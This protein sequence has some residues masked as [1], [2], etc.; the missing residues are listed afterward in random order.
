M[1]LSNTCNYGIRAVLFI[2]TQKE[3]KF[4]PI[5]EISDKLDISFHFL[6]K[7]LQELTRKKMMVSFRGPNGGVAIARPAE[8]IS[9]MEIIQALDGPDLFQK[10]LLGLDNCN[11]NYPCLLHEQWAIIRSNLIKIFENTTIAQAADM[12]E[13]DLFRLTNLVK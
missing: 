1:L 11:D 4:V 12:I 13:Q 7:I 9:L 2:A 5:R 6:T 10:C 8:S 3:R